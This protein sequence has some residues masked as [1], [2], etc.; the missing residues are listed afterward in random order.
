MKL[1]ERFNMKLFVMP[2]MV[3][4][5]ALIHRVVL[6]I[7]ALTAKLK[8]P[9]MTH[10]Q[11]TIK[12][13][14]DAVTEGIST[15]IFSW[16]PMMRLPTPSFALGSVVPNKS[17]STSSTDSALPI[18]SFLYSVSRKGHRSTSR[19]TVDG[20]VSKGNT[21]TLFQSG[22]P[23]KTTIVA[24]PFIY[25]GKSKRPVYD[26][27]ANGKYIGY[28]RSLATAKRRAEARTRSRK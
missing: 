4:V 20:W 27:Y 23:T 25:Q 16:L 5:S 28:A 7:G 13:K 9:A 17:F 26:I 12:A 24:L 6:F 11:M 22:K 21:H 3:R 8:I 19:S 10:F 2:L 14:Q 1:K 15:A 18:P